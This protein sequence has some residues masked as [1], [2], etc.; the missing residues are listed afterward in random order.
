MIKPN[1]LTLEI[2][3][4]VFFNSYVRFIPNQI[5]FAFFQNRIS[6]ILLHL[7]RLLFSTFLINLFIMNIVFITLFLHIHFWLF[8]QFFLKTMCAF[9]LQWFNEKI[10]YFFFTFSKSCAR[11]NLDENK[12]KPNNFYQIIIKW[13]RHSNQ[14]CVKLFTVKKKMVDNS[15]NFH[16]SICQMHE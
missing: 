1:K 3:Y 6:V 7:N 5:L 16:D 8:W 11:L 13:V 14:M 12:W 4:L 2:I 10:K 15:L 9:E